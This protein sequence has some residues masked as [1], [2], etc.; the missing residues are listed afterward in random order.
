MRSRHTEQTQICALIARQAPLLHH[1]VVT[2][3]VTLATGD[4]SSGINPSGAHPE[5]EGV[6]GGG[7][8]VKRRF[9]PE[10]ELGRWTPQRLVRGGKGA[11]VDVPG[12]GEVDELSH[13][14]LHCA[15]GKRARRAA[16]Q[17]DVG[18]GA[19]EGRPGKL[20]SVGGKLEPQGTSLG[21]GRD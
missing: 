3:F 17:D 20:P 5:R 8:K 21:G 9:Q 18:V 6:V 1:V 10:G 14:G 16:G 19:G 13:K 12:P 7:G 2:N 4:R 11:R 15:G